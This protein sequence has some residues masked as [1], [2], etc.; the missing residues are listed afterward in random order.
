MDDIKSKYIAII[1]Q[2]LEDAEKVK[3][4]G[5]TLAGLDVDTHAIVDLDKYT[6]WITRCKSLLLT[7]VG[8]D[9]IYHDAYYK[10]F[11][12]KTRTAQYY[13][14]YRSNVIAGVGIIRALKSGIEDGLLT[15]VRNLVTAR[16]FSDYLGM[17]EHL[18]KQGYKDAAA[19]LIGGTLEN[20]L[21]TIAVKNDIALKERDGIA[22]I[23]NKLAKKE[24]YNELRFK[25][26]QA[27][28]EL[29]NAASH[30]KFSEY[31]LQEVEEFL[32]WTRNFLSQHLT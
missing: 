8:N 16:V 17:A 23:N 2:L 11:C 25:Q 9:G 26:I 24:I 30:A 21:R 27:W 19:V 20:G 31:T 7:I 3:A 18:V 5:K 28:K 32:N 1:Q 29:R 6:E 22:S 15:S 10:E 12:D 4:T 13:E 14:A